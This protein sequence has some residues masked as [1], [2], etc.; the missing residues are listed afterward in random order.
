MSGTWQRGCSN[1][2][3]RPNPKAVAP[4]WHVRGATP[5]SMPMGISVDSAPGEGTHHFAAA[6][7]ATP[8][9]RMTFTRRRALLLVEDD[10]Q[11]RPL[12]ARP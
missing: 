5:V 7:G 1:R 4:A 10:P 12:L 8:V 3:S 11:L 9:C 6:A 2:S